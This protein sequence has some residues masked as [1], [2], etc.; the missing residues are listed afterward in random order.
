MSRRLLGSMLFAPLKKIVPCSVSSVISQRKKEEQVMQFLLS[1]NDQYN[2]V[3]VYMLLM[4][5]IP[6]ITKKLPQWINKNAN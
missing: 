1:L 4:K 5:L 6:S 2:N 3:K